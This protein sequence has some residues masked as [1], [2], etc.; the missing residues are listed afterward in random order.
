MEYNLSDIDLT[1]KS[2]KK[3]LNYDRGFVPKA[4]RSRAFT[5][6]YQNW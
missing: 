4:G 3:W 6:L 5:E 1:Q 2:L